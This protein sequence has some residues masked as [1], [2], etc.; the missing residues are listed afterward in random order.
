MHLVDDR[1]VLVAASHVRLI[2]DHQQQ[3]S[4]TPEVLEGLRHAGQDGEVFGARGRIWL[5]VADDRSVD[6]PIAVEEDRAPTH[7]WVDSHLVWARL[8]FGCETRRCHTTA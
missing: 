3:K 4:G 5:A 7:G 1:S 2:G 6:D 8:S